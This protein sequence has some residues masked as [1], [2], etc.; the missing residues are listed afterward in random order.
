MGKYLLIIIIFLVFS[1]KNNDM[2]YNM[3][4][5]VLNTKLLLYFY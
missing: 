2:K 5:P 3:A 4:K 1:K